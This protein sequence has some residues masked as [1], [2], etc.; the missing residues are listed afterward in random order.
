[1]YTFPLSSSSRLPV[2]P[3]S[4]PL[5]SST[6]SP[7]FHFPPFPLPFSPPPLSPL[8]PPYLP[9]P[10]FSSPPLPPLSSPSPPLPSPP[11]PIFHKT[12]ASL[13]SH[14]LFFLLH[15]SQKLMYNA[16]CRISVLAQQSCLFRNQ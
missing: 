1:M 12:V 16:V 4:S 7:P 3:L 9:L 2:L 6:S 14:S 10:S 11:L 8:P 13:T 5:L 15:F